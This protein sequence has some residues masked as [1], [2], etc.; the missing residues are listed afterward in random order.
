GLLRVLYGQPYDGRLPSY[1]RLDISADQK[2][3][4]RHADVTLQAGLINAY[5][6]DNLFYMDLFTRGRVNQLPVIP[7]FGLKVEIK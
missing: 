5:D 3:E 4:T 1:H 7:S 2:F 6:R